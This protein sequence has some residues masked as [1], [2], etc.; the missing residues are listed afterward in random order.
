MYRLYT[1]KEFASIIRKKPATVRD[2]IN[3][4][5]IKSIKISGYH[6][7]PE[8]E[9]RKVIERHTENPDPNVDRVN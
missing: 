2:W 6:L 3:G 1:T 8:D 7:I 9:L 4:G 5:A